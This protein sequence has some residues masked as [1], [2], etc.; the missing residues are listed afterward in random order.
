MRIG[1]DVS[2]LRAGGGLTHVTELLRAADPVRNRFRDIV[3]WGSAKTLTA[4]E[5][6]AWLQRRHEP[7]LEGSLLHRIFWQ[8]FRLKRL[9]CDAGCDVVFVPGGMDVSRF[10][11][12]V[13]MS[14]NLL[15]FEWN[16]IRRYGVGWH[17]LRLVLLRYA[18]AKTFQRADGV[19]FLTRYARNAVQQAMRTILRRSAIIP[20]GVDS[21]FFHVP[22]PQK[23]REEFDGKKPCR[24][25]YVSMIDFYKHQTNV[26]RAVEQL[27][28]EG[29][30]VRLDL[31]GPPGPGLAQLT[32]M[33]ENRLVAGDAV[34]YVG[35]VP[36]EKLHEFYAIA[37]ISVFASSCE[38]M[39]NILLEGMAAGLPIACSNRGP[40]PEVLGDAG[41]YFD[42]ERPEE[43]AAALSA[44]IR[45]PALRAEKAAAAFNRARAYSWK[46]CAAETFEFL[47]EVCGD[48]KTNWST[49]GRL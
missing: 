6:K 33:L 37:D 22:R 21:R 13:T 18:Q 23:R 39:P 2:N 9:A 32:E 15:P 48:T 31:V 46:R 41:V 5:P 1:I 17:A 29:V 47:A 27:I 7:L 42:P 12:L 44:L 11:P 10:R 40:M 28:A 38:N 35:A 26:V 49:S 8:R 3:I 16:E 36:Y 25:L 20:H 24:L 4:I 45:S 43:I 14:R 34:Q 19:I 30:P